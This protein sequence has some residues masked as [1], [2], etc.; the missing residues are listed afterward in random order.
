MSV[1][2]S[3]KRVAH[4]TLRI[5]TEFATAEAAVFTSTVTARLGALWCRSW[6]LPRPCKVNSVLATT[7]VT[8]QH[9]RVLSGRSFATL[10]FGVHRGITCPCVRRGKLSKDRLPDLTEDAQENI[11]SVAEDTF[12]ASSFSACSTSG[13]CVGRRPSVAQSTSIFI[14]ACTSVGI[15]VDHAVA[16][17][18]Q[19][20]AAA[21]RA[22]EGSILVVLHSSRA[23]G[24]VLPLSTG[25]IRRDG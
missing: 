13:P 15:G 2:I 9:R 5:A 1:M 24:V 6:V 7:F 4:H 19:E 11:I 20:G 12:S 17:A 16:I 3:T 10:G 18:P 21:A 22:S 25:A 8:R 23:V 14:R